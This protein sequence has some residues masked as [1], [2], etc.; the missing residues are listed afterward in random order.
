MW[1]ETAILAGFIQKGKESP[2]K[3]LSRFHNLRSQI[4]GH[5][6]SEVRPGQMKATSGRQWLDT[7][8]FLIGDRLGFGETDPHPGF[9][10]RKG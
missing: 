2:R 5:E 3:L 10:G 9:L 8:N 6:F 4:I 7:E 1:T